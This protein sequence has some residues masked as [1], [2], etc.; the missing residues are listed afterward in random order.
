M[1]ATVHT[2]IARVT[3]TERDGQHALIAWRAGP[4]R[5]VRRSRHKVDI[6]LGIQ[7]TA[8]LAHTYFYAENVYGPGAM[9]L[10]VSPSLFFKQ[11]TAMGGA[12]LQG[13]AGWRYVG[14]GA[15]W[16]GFA[17]DERMDARERRFE[18]NGSWF[19]LIG[20]GQGFVVA[21]TMSE[22][23]KRS[24]PLSLVYVDDITHRA[25]PEVTPGSVPLVGI[26]GRDGQKLAPGRYGFQLN[27]VGL[28]GPQPDD[29]KRAV[30]RLERR[31]TAD[32]TMPADLAAAPGGR[33]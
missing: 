29:P 30:A 6:G 2:G 10:P 5:V 16:P 4:V 24:I 7:L 25:P 23:L 1:E 31:L 3:I 14:P 32:V 8:G 17:V 20:D 18:G 12:D 26:E 15:P 27:I 9:K 22:N 13:M 11:V 21:I 33:R 28:P 19:A